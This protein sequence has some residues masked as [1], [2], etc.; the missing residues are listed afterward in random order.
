MLETLLKEIRMAQKDVEDDLISGS[1]PD[2]AGYKRQVGKAE[3]LALAERIVLD[4][5]EKREIAD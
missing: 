5:I 4:L 1:A 3:G 2:Y